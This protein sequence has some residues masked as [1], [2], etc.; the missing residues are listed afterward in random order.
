M[1]PLVALPDGVC[2][3]RGEVRLNMVRGVVNYDR[4]DDIDY[5]KSLY[6]DWVLHDE[7]LVLKQN[8]DMV[9][10][11]KDKWFI[12]KCSKRGNDV[13][14]YRTEESLK[15]SL[16]DM[17]VRVDRSRGIKKTNA[18]YV[19]NT[20]DT[21]ICSKSMAWSGEKIIKTVKKGKNKGREYLV[22]AD[23]CLCVS[24]AWDLFL[25]KLRKE[26]GKIRVVRSWETF[27]NGYPHVH[28]LIVFENKSFETFKWH[29]KEGRVTWRI[30]SEYK[31]FI[32][33]CWHSFVDV[34]GVVDIEKAVENVVWYVLKNKKSD[35]DYHDVDNWCE[36]DLLTTV[37]TW[38]FNKRS[39]SVSGGFADL[40]SLLCITQTRMS[41]QST[42]YGKKAVVLFEMLGLVPGD[43]A[44]IQSSVWCKVFMECPKWIGDVRMPRV[45]YGSG[46]P[47]DWFSS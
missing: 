36:K 11:H 39:F 30:K 45:S 40:I 15:S 14:Q 5:L 25:S 20:W 7:Y 23:D 33:G 46:V 47:G 26:Y 42:L 18:V 44:K 31:D 10:Y 41:A 4:S 19:T 34:Q 3:S 22:H 16:H 38:F 1:M 43:L 35:R 21:K 8:E 12:L 32:Q 9:N 28:A 37:A 29:D 6:K 24:C 27:E 13:Y 2:N 17:N